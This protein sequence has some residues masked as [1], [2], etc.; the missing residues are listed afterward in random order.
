MQNSS[1][2]YSTNVIPINIQY[3]NTYTRINEKSLTLKSH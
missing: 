2:W 1:K 3:E